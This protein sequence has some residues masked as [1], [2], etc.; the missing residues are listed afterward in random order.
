MS[1]NEDIRGPAAN[2]EFFYAPNRDQATAVGIRVSFDTPRG[3]LKSQFVSAPE[4]RVGQSI[5]G[6]L[7]G[8]TKEDPDRS[9]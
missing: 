9:G 5:N 3:R 8:L 6:A 1:S 2:A 4:L 7:A